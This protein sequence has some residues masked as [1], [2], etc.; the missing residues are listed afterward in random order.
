[1]KK[2]LSL[3]YLLFLAFIN[4]SYALV[5]VMRLPD[6]PKTFCALSKGVDEDKGAIRRY[7]LLYNTKNHRGQE[8]LASGL[9]AFREDVEKNVTPIL[10]LHATPKFKEDVPSMGS[11]ESKFMTCRALSQKTVIIAPDYIGLG[12][13]K[14]EHPYMVKDVTIS[15]SLDFFNAAQDWLQ[16]KHEI[17]TPNKVI[18]AGYSQ[19]GHAV[20]AVHKHLDETEADLKVL[21]TYSMSG[22]TSLSTNMLHSM[23]YNVPDKNTAFFAAVTL[24]TFQA[25]Y[26]NV[27]ENTAFIPEFEDAEDLGVNIDKNGLR[28]LLPRD[29]RESIRPELLAEIEADPEHPFRKNLEANDIHPWKASA[30]ITMTYTKVDTTIPPSDGAEFFQKMK[31]IEGNNIRRVASSEHI[32]HTANFL[33]STILFTKELRASGL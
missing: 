26:R 7:A 17:F 20:L 2:Q 6:L 30:P 19:G 24:T 8:V 21:K 15:A 27:Y 12:H 23:L 10:Y 11:F 4:A 28:D 29:P 13:S 5:G 1:M 9:V 25:H 31:K 16:N 18:L 14:E 3:A 32:P 33:L 22:P